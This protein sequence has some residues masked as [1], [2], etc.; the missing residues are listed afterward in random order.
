VVAQD[1]QRADPVVNSWA[2][3]GMN[4]RDS[5]EC[6]LDPD[7]LEALE[8]EQKKGEEDWLSSLNT[9]R[10]SEHAVTVPYRL[11]ETKLS[12]KWQPSEKEKKKKELRR[13]LKIDSHG[14][15]HICKSFACTS[16][17]V[18]CQSVHLTV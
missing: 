8:S 12:Q 17:S 3:A 18:T 1:W 13:G 14:N 7:V 6:I 16:N 10:D 4:V 2:L 9:M 11:L 15:V 5:T